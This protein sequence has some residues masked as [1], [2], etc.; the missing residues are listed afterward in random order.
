MNRPTSQPMSQ[1]VKIRQW[2]LAG[3]VALLALVT[4]SLV[5]QLTAAR[6]ARNERAWFEAQI[7]AMIPA[8][9][10][11]NDLLN[12]RTLVIAPDAL[13]DRNPV[14]IYYHCAGARLQ[15]PD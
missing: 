3:F 6:I 8:V 2:L 14:A 4:L 12:D 10:H 5:N 13:G 9:L 11:D 7:D 15:W 1:S